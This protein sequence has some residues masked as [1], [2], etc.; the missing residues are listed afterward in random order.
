MQI[1]LLYTELSAKNHS[2]SSTAFRGLGHV[3][4]NK[5]TILIQFEP[6]ANDEQHHA[7][8][9]DPSSSK[10]KSSRKVQARRSH[11]LSH[12]LSHHTWS[13]EVELA[14]DKTALRS[15]KGDTGSVL[16]KARYAC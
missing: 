4:S 12:Q 13:L 3:D 5:D 11:Q 8:S 14:Q 2:D 10:Y 7:V 1:F 15:R 16:W 6:D 9:G